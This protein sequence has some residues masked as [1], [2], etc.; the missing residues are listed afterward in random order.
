MGAS[1]RPAPL[2]AALDC[3]GRATSLLR[4]LAASPARAAETG[5]SAPEPGGSTPRSSLRVAPGW[6]STKCDGLST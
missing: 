4:V 5:R 2:P 3:P 6:R 1:P